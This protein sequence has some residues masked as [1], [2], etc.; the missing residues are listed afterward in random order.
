MTAPS[1]PAAPLLSERL[2]PIILGLYRAVAAKAARD[3]ALA[4]M[5]VLLCQQLSRMV[6]R[7]A[8]VVRRA[9]Q[10]GVGVPRARPVG[11][12]PSG[13]R[14]RLPGGF[15]W[16]V[17]LM[18]EAAIYGSQLQHALSDPE[19]AASLAAAPQAGRVLRP[20]CRMLGVEPGPALSSSAA[21]EIPPVQGDAPKRR[22]E[23]GAQGAQG[24]VRARRSP[25]PRPFGRAWLR[26]RPAGAG[27]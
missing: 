5:L 13:P 25:V 10:A 12:R 20:L 1:S 14:V 21:R 7:L 6:V 19:V 23:A 27:S 3:R 4:P 18:P 24:A 2:A 17:R 11:P 16:L 22:R 26:W 8:R 15:A 9:R